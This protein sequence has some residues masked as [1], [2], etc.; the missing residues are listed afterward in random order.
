MGP[1]RRRQFGVATEFVYRLHR[2]NPS[3]YGGSLTYAVDKDFLNFYTELHETLPFEANVAP[4]LVPGA[5]EK[6]LIPYMDGSVAR[7]MSYTI[8]CFTGTR[9]F[10]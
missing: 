8:A 2:F 9:F 7:L 5:G 1:A 3:A 6:G 10:R 4:N